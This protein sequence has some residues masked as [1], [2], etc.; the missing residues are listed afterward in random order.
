MRAGIPPSRCL[1]ASGSTRSSAPAE[2]GR[3]PSAMTS[4]A[5][6]RTPGQ[7]GAARLPPDALNDA[8]APESA[9]DRVLAIGPDKAVSV[10][11][12]G[13]WEGGHALG[14]CRSSAQ[15]RVARDAHHCPPY[16]AASVISADRTVFN[17]KGNDCRLVVAVDDDKR[18]VWIEWI[19][20]HADDDRSDALGAGH[21]R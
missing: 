12:G 2:P 19:G 4:W 21:G 13:C 8:P 5:R 7:G 20:A 16:R 17:I 11:F 3:P 10:L 14:T 15:G 18:I 9:E 1:A 6:P